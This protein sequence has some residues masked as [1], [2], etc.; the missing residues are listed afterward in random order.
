LPNFGI[1]ALWTF[2]RDI[3]LKLQ[4]VFFPVSK[5]YSGSI[6][7]LKPGSCSLL[8]FLPLAVQRTTQHF[9]EISSTVQGDCW[10]PSSWLKQICLT[11]YFYRFKRRGLYVFPMTVNPSVCLCVH[12]TGSRDNTKSADFFFYETWYTERWQ[13][14]DS[15][16]VRLRH[17]FQCWKIWLL[18]QQRDWN[19][20]NLTH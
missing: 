10:L 20:A 14:G 18:W 1:I 8:L 12:K 2:S 11:I 7:R 4:E 3:T 6:T 5:T 17:F 15:D 16:Y 9:V 13:P 19:M